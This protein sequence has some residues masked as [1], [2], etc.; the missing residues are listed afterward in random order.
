M[1]PRT[2]PPVKTLLATRRTIEAAGFALHPMTTHAKGVSV[3]A[4]QGNL[5]LRSIDADGNCA[6]AFIELLEA[7]ERQLRADLRRDR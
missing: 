4:T 5:V 1:N 3:T 7:V 2:V 6:M